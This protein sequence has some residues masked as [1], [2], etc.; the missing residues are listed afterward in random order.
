MNLKSLYI[1]ALVFLNVNLSFGNLNK[2]DTAVINDWISI[3][4]KLLFKKP[5]S[6]S[7]F[8]DSIYNASKKIDYQ[9]GLYKTYSSKAVIIYM[10]GDYEQSIYEYEKAFPYVDEN[11]P[12]QEIRLYNNIAY[13]LR[14]LGFQDSA[15]LYT[16]R[17]SEIAL[18]KGLFDFY[19]QSVLDI[20][21]TYLDMDKYIEAAEYYHI[22]EKNTESSQDK[23]YLIKAYSSLAMFYYRIEDFDKSYDFYFQ[24]IKIDENYDELDLLN[25]NYANLGL[26]Y[27]DV[28]YDYD[29][30]IYFFRKSIQLVRSYE[31]PRKQLMAN[32]NIGNTFIDRNILDSA[33]YYYEL[34][35]NDTLLEDF[36]TYQA[37]VYTNMGM[38]HLRN[39][40]YQKARAF[41][42]DGLELSMKY[43]LLRFQKNA[44]RELSS[45]D[46]IQGNHE[47]ALMH[48]KLF[49]Q[50][51]ESLKLM[52]V[53]NQ[54]AI[55]E[56]EKF[57][58]KEKYNY[59][60]LT[61][62]NEN[63]NQEI[64][65]QR[66]VIGTVFLMVMVLVVIIVI[67]SRNRKKINSLN[68]DLQ[69]S[70]HSLGELNKDLMLQRK[71]MK[72]LLMSKDRFVSILGH[73]LKNPFTGLLGLLE[74]MELDWDE[75][76][77][78][79]KKEGIQQLNQS[80]IQ[81]Y[82]LLEDLLDWGKT[83]QGLIKAEKEEF[84]V[85][86][87]FHE[88]KTI[89]S[90]QLKKKEIHLEMRAEEGYIVNSDHKLCSQILQNL[91]GN[92][93]KYSQ[94]GGLISMTLEEQDGQVLI[95]V[96]DEGIGIP[97][98]KIQGLFKLDCNFNR[99][100]TQNEKSSGM[101]LLLVKEYANIIGAEIRVESDV[102][103]GTAFC[104]VMKK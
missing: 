44:H 21:S 41:L 79:E 12:F 68:T 90:L 3:S 57:M 95:C 53:N 49:H 70:N 103:K 88:V 65:I 102:N 1:I 69:S 24:A 85:F 60:L 55:L 36:P 31:L 17:G 63:Q 30:A 42:N 48:Y 75:M 37:A 34:V 59:E 46:S 58:A 51:S 96:I 61:K 71:E 43:E 50:I 7:L 94:V 14:S 83:Q 40:D 80:S 101:G 9:Y 22:V 32:I 99:P 98:D 29:S 66:A 47:D 78:Q 73:D 56:Y 74:L 62:E 84:K 28:A 97:K 100:G 6:A 92:A 4:K 77:D 39:K 33:N 91:L 8:L 15:L 18:E 25:V 104:L 5:D 45:L 16:R 76:P 11:V 2:V 89:F 10:R 86:N 26:L 52:E 20:A 81:T 67:V 64:I 35:Y 87:L 38:Y 82:R 13:S 27:K 72:D 93:I 19:Q 23:E 54:M